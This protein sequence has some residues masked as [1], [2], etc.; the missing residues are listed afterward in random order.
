MSWTCSYCNTTFEDQGDIR[1]RFCQVCGARVS[2]SE[3]S[4]QEQVLDG[5]L[6]L[7]MLV[8]GI[9]WLVLFF[10]PFGT[11]SDYS[12]VWSW[13]LLR[14]TEDMAYLVA[15]PLVLGMI[16]IVLGIASPLPRWLRHG[17][18]L[19]LSFLALGVLFGTE[20]GGPFA[21]EL[22]FLFAGG[23][24]WMLMFFSVGTALLLLVRFSDVLGPKLFLGFGLL[25]GLVAYLSPAMTEYTL[26]SALLYQVGTGDAAHI[27]TRV[28]LLLPMYTLHVHVLHKEEIYQHIHIFLH[29]FLV[30]R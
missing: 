3:Q 26:V 27:I 14:N 24:C 16:F 25:L 15:W 13:D 12:P 5:R 19:L 1:V 10:I 6:R 8:F 11:R 7:V 30:N 18:G 20:S 17:G 4:E 29:I 28:L 2:A 9:L 23:A 22:G 21:K